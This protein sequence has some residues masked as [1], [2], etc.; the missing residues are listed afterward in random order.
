MVWRTEYPCNL[1]PGNIR[2][3]VTLLSA[4]LV[5]VRAF[6]VSRHI[7]ALDAAALRQQLSVYKRKQLR[8][9][10]VDLIGCSGLLYAVYGRIGLRLSFWSNQIQWCPG[11]APDSACSGA[12]GLVQV[13]LDGRE[14]RERSGT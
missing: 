14:W 10:C 8:P 4:V 3:M 7:L 11:I 1:P 2:V 5:Y 9:S 6:L 12:G 13:K